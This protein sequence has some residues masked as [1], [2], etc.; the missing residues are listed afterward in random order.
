MESQIESHLHYLTFDEVGITVAVVGIAL[1]FI[2]L[3]WNA[4]KAIHDWRLMAKKPTDDRIEDH[5]RRITNLEH[6][7]EEVHGKLQN[8][9][10]FQ[11]DETEMN[12]LMLKSIKQLL[13]HSI[14]GNDTSGLKHMEDEIDN[15]LVDHAQ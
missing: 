11:Q 13:K 2:V 10:Q 9:W 4:V 15:Y 7:C 8:D 5:E 1:A 3:V 14:D 12:R 6:C